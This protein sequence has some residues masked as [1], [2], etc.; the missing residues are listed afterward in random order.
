MGDTA[1]TRGDLARAPATGRGCHPILVRL[2]YTSL[3][4]VENGMVTRATGSR[5]AVQEY[6]AV[7]GNNGSALVL[8]FGCRRAPRVRG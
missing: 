2:V 7:V 5:W 8:G 6:L 3:G 1:W 4:E